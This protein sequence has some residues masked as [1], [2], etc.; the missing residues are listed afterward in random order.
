[1][2]SAEAKTYEVETLG[3]HGGQA[4]DPATG[5]R[6]VPIY[7]TSSFTFHNTKHAAELFALDEPGHIYSRISNPTT[8]VLEKRIA[9]MEGGVGALATG[10]GQAAATITMLTLL[11]AGD[12]VVAA[13]TLYGG[14]YHL[15]ADTLPKFGVKTTFVDPDEPENFRKAVTDKTK[16]IY[17]E[18]IGNP[19]LNVLDIE[20][21]AAI[22]KE[23]K[24]PLILDCT[25][26]TPYILQAFNYGCN[27]VRYFL[28]ILNVALSMFV[29]FPP[30]HL[31]SS[32]RPQNGSAATARPSAG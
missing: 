32:T 17:A 6:A 28:F 21:V 1:M 23:N 25:F 3:L 26:T 18:T 13:S 15:L 2:A 5:A 16:A 30:L 11:Q 20:K 24:I 27:I 14:T 29:F 12:E 7:Q 8:D 19:K 9:L 10:S 22:A 31:R 4:P